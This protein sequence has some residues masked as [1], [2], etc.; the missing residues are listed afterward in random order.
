MPQ[1][2]PWT[3]GRLL[4]W[5]RAY[6]QEHGS[7]TPRLDAEVLLAEA[8]G[9][10]RI[11]LYTAFDDVPPEPVRTAFRELVRR[12]AEGAP[13]AYLVGYREFFSLPFYVTADVL[14]PRP[15]TELLVIA[16]LERA[17]P[18]L[19]RGA[20]LWICDVG[21]GSGA[22]AVSAAV[23]LK[24]ARFVAI[25]RSRAALAVAQQNARRHAVD[26]SIDLVAG[27]LLDCIASEPCCD[28]IVSNPPYV[29]SS[30]MARLDRDVADY[31]PHAALE[32][33]PRGTEVIERLLPAAAE[34]LKAGGWLLVEISPTIAADA[35]RL[36]AADERFDPPQVIPDLAQLP[37]VVAAE[38]RT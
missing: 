21:T 25:D 38:R 36:I 31:E 16:L 12:R 19:E 7:D 28:F 3:V 26:E 10:T 29:K 14:I 1:T 2:E 34:R 17:R 33:G 35:E 23:H 11:D 18:R 15:E 6:L 30:E 37:R 5:T 4:E 22:I 32:A 27:N 20:P 8:R 9:C 13:V 24:G